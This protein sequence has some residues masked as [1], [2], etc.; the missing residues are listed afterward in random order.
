MAQIELHLRLTTD[1][2]GLPELR[3][4]AGLI[5]D[6][7]R[8]ADS[9]IARCD[10]FVNEARREYVAMIVH[11]CAEGMELH[12]RAAA[13]SYQALL[14]HATAALDIFGPASAASL[15]TL[16][17]FRLRQFHYADGLSAL[18]ARP[19]SDPPI[20]IYTGFA[21]Q[22]GQLEQFKRLARELTEV[23]RT[24]DPGTARY[25]WFYNDT[26]SLCIA[27]DT[28]IDAQ[29]MFAHM[30]NCHD[31]HEKL[32][33]ISTMTTD[34]LGELPPQAM[35]AVARYDPYILKFFGGLQSRSSG[36]L[37]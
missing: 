26:A 22:A 11:A 12:Q 3:R 2:P 21:I 29:A 20:E 25:D 13:G 37:N 17:G 16:G 23:V 5:L 4:I 36:G 35:L 10:W 30:S 9:G 19:L 24:R 32:L 7:A 33:K 18:G 14:V 1:E 27:M 28:Y 8:C 15:A 31:A 6:A 34:F